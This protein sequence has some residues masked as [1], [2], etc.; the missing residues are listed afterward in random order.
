[1]PEANKEPSLKDRFTKD[2]QGNLVLNYEFKD[3]QKAHEAAKTLDG[4][5]GSFSQLLGRQVAEYSFKAG[6]GSSGSYKIIIPADRAS[7][8]LAP[9]DSIDTFMERLKA[10]RAIG[11]I[12]SLDIQTAEQQ[13]SQDG[14]KTN[15]LNIARSGEPGSF[16]KI[17][18][19]VDDNPEL[20]LADIK[21]SDGLNLLQVMA[22][23]ATKANVGVLAQLIE[24]HSELTTAKIDKGKTVEDYV[25]E[26][27]SLSDTN[28]GELVAALRQAGGQ[29][30]EDLQK[31]PLTNIAAM[32]STGVNLG[33][34]T[35]LDGDTGAHTL[36]REDRF[37]DFKRVIAKHRHLAYQ[38]N[39]DHL[40]PEDG[41]NA[42]PR[43]L[44]SEKK[45]LVAT[46]RQA[47]AKHIE[48]LLAQG[49]FDKV[50]ELITKHPELILEKVGDIEIVTMIKKSE[51]PKL[52]AGM[53][54]ALASMEQ[55]NRGEQ[56]TIVA[57]NAPP[58][59]SAAAVAATASA[60]Y[61]STS[62]PAPAAQPENAP[63]NP[64]QLDALFEAIKNK[65]NDAIIAS[66]DAS[67]A[68]LTAKN[69]GHTPMHFAAHFGNTDA[70]KV[71]FE[72][73][74]E[75]GKL[76]EVLTAKNNDGNIPAHDAANRSNTDAL[77]MILEKAD[78]IGKLGEV[79]TAKN[80]Y[81]EMPAHFAAYQGHA[82]TLKLILDT[83][84][85]LGKL[86]EVLSAKSEGGHTPV[87]LAAAN[88][89]A[90]AL[91]TILEKDPRLLDDQLR[92]M[93]HNSD[94][95][96]GNKALMGIINA[97]KSPSEL[98]NLHDLHNAISL[99]DTA[100]AVKLL[101]AHPKLFTATRDDSNNTAFNRVAMTGDLNMFTAMV[102]AAKN[103]DGVNINEVLNTKNS[104]GETPLSIAADRGYADLLLVAAKNGVVFDP[105]LENIIRGNDKLNTNKELMAMVDPDAHDHTEEKFDRK[106]AAV[107]KAIDRLDKYHYDKKERHSTKDHA[108]TSNEIDRLKRAELKDLA[109]KFDTD[110]DGVITST[111]V[112]DGLRKSKLT[113]DL[114]AIAKQLGD[115]LKLAGVNYKDSAS[116]D[117]TQTAELAK[118]EPTQSRSTAFGMGA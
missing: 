47:G 64:E 28:K 93:V 96:S 46:I 24:A 17:K 76:G 5:Q 114:D 58:T 13:K 69:G 38:E 83:A 77:K 45:E 14:L 25:R 40:T 110:K 97:H 10:S 32:E 68:L 86:D 84:E 117:A 115:R 62:L 18:S 7:D 37:E 70:L 19:I 94:A 22:L 91:R 74:G 26:N 112:E 89:N 102:E 23:Y 82:D 87:Y 56:E 48:T 44:K 43:L 51:S 108:L 65:N 111:E 55:K 16:E 9:S 4:L 15:I 72:K 41:I 118:F 30:R 101:V 66:L 52:I 113:M 71:I 75:L 31:N 103:A 33:A 50:D 2:D 29:S 109:G 92:E 34:Y 8:I 6:T 39:D 98:K 57:A 100:A 27:A 90:D 79:L 53:N 85:K 95:L 78:S 21:T 80:N 107:G 54:T 42:N 36:I 81:G 20:N 12:I 104:K 60:G 1:M 35:E 116:H 49:K 105:N 3:L 63:V 99:D 11:E 59:P 67:P 73:A 106:T 88:S 61:I